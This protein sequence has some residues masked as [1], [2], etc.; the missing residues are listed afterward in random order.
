MKFL[1]ILTAAAL[2]LTVNNANAQ[3]TGFSVQIDVNPDTVCVGN[4][5]QIN[6]I[7]SNQNSSVSWQLPSGQV[8][9]GG[10]LYTNSVTLA[11]SGRYI[12]TATY[13][14]C[15]AKDT[16]YMKVGQAPQ[17]PWVTSNGPICAG[18]TLEIEIMPA[19]I[20]PGIGYALYDPSNNKIGSGK[21][22]KVPNATTAMQGGYLVI[23]FDPIG[24]GNG[25]Y[26]YLAP[27]TINTKPAK[28]TIVASKNPAC[29]GE[30]VTLSHTG[31]N[32]AY[33]F[34]W[35]DYNNNKVTNAVLNFSQTG[36]AGS[37]RFALQAINNGCRSE[38]D[39]M[40]VVIEPKLSPTLNV[41]VNP[42]TKVGPYAP[43][44]FTANAANTGSAATYQWVKNGANIQGETGMTL[45]M[46]AGQDFVSGDKISVSVNTNNTCATP[47]SL[48]SNVSTMQI[49]LS[50]GDMDSKD[51]IRFYPNPVQDK[52]IVE[53]AAD[54]QLT[55]T[56]INGM[57]VAIGNR[58]SKDGDKVIINTVGLPAGVYLLRA[59]N[60]AARFTKAE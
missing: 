26:F 12:A 57:Q 60:K 23:V 58:L 29:V 38:P 27:N 51:G 13:G 14:S 19:Q 55:L 20:F 30:S 43:V 21:V 11:D 48:N 6:P 9:N 34:E 17:T 33:S 2:A 16:F 54:E 37:Y 22:T 35:T 52:L 40:D 4:Y 36:S 41:T 47:T 10:A 1:K 32:P 25:T 8:L 53:G 44:M 39:T 7:L 24:C 28:P 42:G 3:C 45:S 50:V 18:D 49:D 31:I 5:V 15:V 59:G 46:I 56:G